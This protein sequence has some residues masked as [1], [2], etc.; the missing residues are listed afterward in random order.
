MFISRH[1]T[2]KATAKK[3]SKT[4]SNIVVI[5]CLPVFLLFLRFVFCVEVFFFIVSLYCESA[6]PK[7]DNH[8]LVL[9]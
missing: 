5:R 1:E 9:L 4:T 8:Q 6:M 7:P 3:F 2:L